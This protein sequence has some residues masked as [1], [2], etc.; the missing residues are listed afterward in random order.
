VDIV[1]ATTN[2]DKVR[3][4]R[5]ALKDLIL[6]VLTL[7][8][9]P[10]CPAVEEDEET[11]R[12]NALKKAT[13]VAQFSGMLSL[14]DDSGLEVEALGGAPGVLSRRFSG[15]GASY[16]DNNVKLL[17]LLKEVPAD[18]RR[19]TF[20]CVIAIIQGKK[21]RVAEGACEGIILPEIAGSNG[22]G[23]DPLFQPEGFDRSFAQMSL[24]E[25]DEVSHRGKALRKAKDLLKIWESLVVV[26]L[27]G[28]IGSGK[29]TIA[30][31]FRELGAEVIE[32]DK[33]GH[34]VLENEEVRQGIAKS[35]GERVLDKS[36][37]V[38]RQKLRTIVFR[39][40]KRL[41]ELNSIIHPSMLKEMERRIISSEARIIVVDAAI[42]LEAGWDSLVDRV[43]V[44]TASGETRR[45]RMQESS[46]LSPEEIEGVSR[47]Q[48]SQDEKI[49][50]AD[51]LV[52]NEH[53][54]DKSK[55]QV[56]RIWSKLV[57]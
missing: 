13:T 45:R 46:R 2:P 47:A 16:E 50:R 20:R 31:M 44:V 36:G 1:L 48:S 17:S 37:R 57:A 3:E 33:V 41:E 18:E 14:A 22:F 9:L 55:E 21:K 38:E 4:I 15:Q 40:D 43:L 30:S 35:F 49:A 26:G 25:K 53:D 51:F 19:A 32:A 29:S 10:D 7:E 5:D 24:K 28:N 54:I 6:R 11:L 12:G 42:L 8:D 52:E 34:S 56:R 39:N 27:T 23:Y